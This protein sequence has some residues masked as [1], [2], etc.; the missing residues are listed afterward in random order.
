MRNQ[1]P[2]QPSVEGSAV[3]FVAH[4]GFPTMAWGGKTSHARQGAPWSN[5]RAVLVYQCT[6]HP[7]FGTLQ[8]I[9]SVWCHNDV[10]RLG[11]GPQEARFQPSPSLC[12]VWP[13]RVFSAQHPE[14]TTGIF[15]SI[16]ALTPKPYARL[17]GYFVSHSLT[18]LLSYRVQEL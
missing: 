9:K 2:W 5:Q 17:K 10:T 18:F 15:Q 16:L 14:D 13:M 12:K 4:H 11:N 7:K 1:C 3:V 6:L 8:F